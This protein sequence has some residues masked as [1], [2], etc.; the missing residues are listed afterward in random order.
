M[1]GL[2]QHMHFRRSWRLFG[3]GTLDG[4]R[5]SIPMM[6]L[7]QVFMGNLVNNGATKNRFNRIEQQLL[8]YGL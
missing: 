8:I 3:T 6:L 4:S 5:F 1:I 7:A 2:S